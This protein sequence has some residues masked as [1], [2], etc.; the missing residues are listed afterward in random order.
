MSTL[1]PQNLIPYGSD[2]AVAERLRE[3]L[4]AA[5]PACARR[6]E[7]VAL[8]G[9]DALP[10]EL[11]D[12]RTAAPEIRVL[13]AP[14]WSDSELR[15]LIR[16]EVAERLAR[17]AE[18]LPGGV[19]L[20]FWEGLRPLSVQRSLWSSGIAFLKEAHPA[21]TGADLETML[22]QYVAR[23]QGLR[24]PH[25]TGSAVDVAALDAFGQ[26][27][28]P[29]DAWGRLGYDALARR[30]REAGLANYEPEWWHWSYGD[31]EWA[32]ANDCAP[33]TFHALPELDGAGDGI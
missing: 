25:S 33:L 4:M 30:L 6:A 32:R 19:Y 9:S 15:F 27:M 18:G 7:R 13:S 28:N 16:P 22:E 23:P 1:H 26:V 5:A 8:E 31:E 29:G 17:A 12:V 11:V 14:A 10:R 2:A 21:A 20:G 3:Y 24:P